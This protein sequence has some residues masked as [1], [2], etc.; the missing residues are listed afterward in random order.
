MKNEVMAGICSEN[1]NK[2]EVIAS[3]TEAMTVFIKLFLLNENRKRLKMRENPAMDS[4]TFTEKSIKKI[5]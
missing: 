2:Y 5:R 4:K 1:R 3:T